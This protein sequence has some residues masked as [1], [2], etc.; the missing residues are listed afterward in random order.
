MAKKLTELEPEEILNDLHNYV[1]KSGLVLK[2]DQRKIADDK[3]TLILNDGLISELL[4]KYKKDGNKIE[5]NLDE[6][7]SIRRNRINNT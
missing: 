4:E 2:E 1:S 7:K 5:T 3:M 6:K